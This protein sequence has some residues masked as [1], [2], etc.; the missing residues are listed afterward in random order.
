MTKSKKLLSMQSETNIS[1][2]QAATAKKM[3][4]LVKGLA[5]QAEKNYQKSIVEGS[6]LD[7]DKLIC[8]PDDLPKLK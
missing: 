4:Q 5:E 8:S 1:R 6:I 3:Q 2:E 7:T